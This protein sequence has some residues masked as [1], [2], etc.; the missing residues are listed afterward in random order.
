M[1]TL[2][3]P[4]HPSRRNLT[5]LA[6]SLVFALHVVSAHAAKTELPQLTQRVGLVEAQQNREVGE[7]VLRELQSKAPL[8]TDPWLQ[9][10]LSS[11]L[12][13]INAHA[14]SDA[15]L[16]MVM[17]K[18]PQI[19]AFAVPGGV[20]GINTGLVNKARNADE[21]ASVLAHEVAHVSQKHFQRRSEHAKNDLL[22]QL[23]GIIASALIAKADPEA[24]SAIAMGSQAYTVDKKLAYSREHEREADRIG[25]QIMQSAGY[26]PQA[27]PTF[28]ELM[29]NENRHVG[30]LPSF[31]LTHPLTDERISE[32]RQRANNL[33]MKPNYYTQ[34]T[35]KMFPFVQWRMRALDK[36]ANLKQFYAAIKNQSAQSDAARMGLVTAY[37]GKERY[38]EAQQQ[39]NALTKTY[40]ETELYQLNQAGIYIGQRNTAA[41]VTLLNKAHII[42]PESR[43]LTLA[44][45]DALR[46]SQQYDK[47][48]QVV[49]P[50]V[51]KNPYDIVAW[52]LLANTA[53][54][55][56]K[57]TINQIRALRY[58]AEVKFW[59]ND[60][61]GALI[62]LAR[63]K[64]LAKAHPSHLAKINTRY[65]KI[66]QVQTQQ[67]R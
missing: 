13:A 63:A 9:D 46:V 55:T 25:M 30:Y 60:L 29:H 35:Q 1:R 47:A 62:T 24:A 2:T 38:K 44:L 64:I 19:N 4:Y 51:R 41:A 7:W 37:I 23:G 3:L 16:A 5:A 61:E 14:R 53:A 48:L 28:F 22:I 49:K 36:R 66:K 26:D 39:L 59:K 33:V 6:A 11:M 50:L 31:A 45:G 67:H 27:M 42:F 58:G 52:Q 54:Q 15:P 18:N 56:P 65:T 8:M 43:S 10:E 12:N 21:L 34:K 32:S 57:T 17:I 20:I 40:A